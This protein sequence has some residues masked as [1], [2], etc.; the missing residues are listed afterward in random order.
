MRAAGVES[1]VRPLVTTSAEAAD[2][3]RGEPIRLLFVDGL[4]TEEAVLDDVCL[5]RRWWTDDC[6]VVI[7][8][9][10]VFPGVCA[11]VRRLRRAGLLR[12][13][14]LVVGKMIGFGPERLLSSVPTPPG[15]RVM[16]RLGDR[17]LSLFD[18]A[19]RDRRSM[20]EA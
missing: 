14:P 3:W 17:A 19:F 12:G 2:S 5:W 1:H 18:L 11:A 13:R 10:L 15:A 16:G 20:R 7:D 8:D 6:C 9:Y 4:H